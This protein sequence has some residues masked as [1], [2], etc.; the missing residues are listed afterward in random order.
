ME[1]YQDWSLVMNGGLDGLI[2]KQDLTFS[3]MTGKNGIVIWMKKVYILPFLQKTYKL[4]Q[5]LVRLKYE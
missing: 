3:L 2:M 5:I 1:L 4:Y